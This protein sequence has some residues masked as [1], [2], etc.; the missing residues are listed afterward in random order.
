MAVVTP[1]MGRDTQVTLGVVV[2]TLV[3][4]SRRVVM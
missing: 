3:T 2:V 4:L 1:T